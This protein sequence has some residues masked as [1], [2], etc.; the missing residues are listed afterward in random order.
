MIFTTSCFRVPRK[1]RHI[2][3]RDGWVLRIP[4]YEFITMT[5][6]ARKTTASTFEVIP[7]P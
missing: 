3:I 1:A 4:L 5:G 7:I 6:A 2:W